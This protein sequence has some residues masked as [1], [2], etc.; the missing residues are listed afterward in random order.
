MN[1][2]QYSRMYEVFAAARR[3]SRSDRE[4]YLLAACEDDNGLRA[5]VEKL[6]AV[7]ARPAA[8]DNSRSAA[9]E[10]LEALS[11]VVGAPVR[12]PPEHIG[13]YRIHSELGRGGMGVV[14]EAEQDDPRRRVALKVIRTSM[15]SRSLLQRFR[16]EARVLGHLHGSSFWTVR[17]GPWFRHVV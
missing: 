8:I 6:L 3:L 7:D 5:E 2:E 10:S 15:V 16:H 4:H 12:S 9:R 13:H 14:Y 1:A 17:W 11:L